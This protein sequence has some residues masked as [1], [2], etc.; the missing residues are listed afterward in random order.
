MKSVP[1]TYK[2]TV[3]LMLS[4]GS[5]VEPEPRSEIKLPPGAE[6]EIMNCGSGSFLFTTDLR[7]FHRKNHSC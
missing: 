2:G 3:W 7:K 5:V 1:S 4:E 6:A